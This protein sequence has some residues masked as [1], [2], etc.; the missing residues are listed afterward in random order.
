MERMVLTEGSGEESVF[1]VEWMNT[2]TVA[3]HATVSKG[4]TT[5]QQLDREA[6][7]DAPWRVHGS[8]GT[9]MSTTREQKSRKLTETTR[10]NQKS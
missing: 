1:S 9:S 3:T 6:Q 2:A 7:V 8:R 4:Q 10:A 5:I